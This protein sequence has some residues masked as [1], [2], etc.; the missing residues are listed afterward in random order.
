MNRVQ[1]FLYGLKRF[2]SSFREYMRESEQGKHEKCGCS[3]AFMI[4][5]AAELPFPFPDQSGS[6]NRAE[7]GDRIS[8]CRSSDHHAE[9]IT[10]HSGSFDCDHPSQS[11]DS[12]HFSDTAPAD[13]GHAGC[14]GD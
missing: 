4:D 13:S 10:S 7:T 12:G 1:R 3:D 8:L 5:R 14:S 9:Q 6:N 2:G 11:H